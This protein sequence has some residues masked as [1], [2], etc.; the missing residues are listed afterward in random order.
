MFCGE[1][2]GEAA[3]PML[4]A[5]AIPRMRALEKL[6]SEGRL[7][8]SGWMLGQSLSRHE[9]KGKTYLDDRETQ[10]WR[11]DITNPH[12][13]NHSNK[14]V[15]NQNSPGSCTCFAENESSHHLS[16]MKLRKCCCNCE[17]PKQ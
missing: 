10:Y 1:A 13:E 9:S 17:A 3:P 14:H 5:R 16:N 8:R 2:I 7:R 6:E 11:C 12:A 4:E 15:G